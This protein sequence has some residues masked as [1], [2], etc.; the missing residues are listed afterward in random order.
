M[1]GP[2]GAAQDEQ[3]RP[4]QNV[5]AHNRVKDPHLKHAVPRADLRLPFHI[6]ADEG[7]PLV[8]GLAILELAHPIS[9]DIAIEDID[10]GLGA[11]IPDSDGIIRLHVAAHNKMFSFAYVDPDTPYTYKIPFLGILSGSQDPAPG[12]LR[13]WRHYAFNVIKYTTDPPYADENTPE[14]AN[15]TL[16]ELCEAIERGLDAIDPRASDGTYN[17]YCGSAPGVYNPEGKFVIQSTDQNIQLIILLTL[18]LQ[19]NV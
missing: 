8:P 19:K 13:N 7:N 11:L 1:L 9:A 2:R 18:I 10:L 16:Q 14:E 15:L 17:V 5:P 12:F 3:I 4:E 6:E